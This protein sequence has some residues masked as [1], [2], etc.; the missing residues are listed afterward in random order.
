MPG[1]KEKKKSTKSTKDDTS[2][3]EDAEIERPSAQVSPR[4][5]LE[6]QALTPY[7]TS[8]ESESV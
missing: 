2:P 8:T 6:M 5:S 3:V 1:I 7:P 4:N